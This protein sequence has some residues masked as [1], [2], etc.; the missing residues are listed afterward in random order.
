MCLRNI[1]N[2]AALYWLGW[3]YILK[4]VIYL[5]NLTLVFKF[6]GFYFFKNTILIFY[7]DY[8]HLKSNFLFP[9]VYINFFF[10]LFLKGYNF[11]FL[12]TITFYVYI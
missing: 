1:E 3:M 5:S 2:D 7:I 12:N 11:L 8:C 6:I 10:F 9:Y 4:R